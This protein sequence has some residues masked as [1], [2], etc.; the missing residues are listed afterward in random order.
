LWE[1]VEKTWTHLVEK[2]RK[3]SDLEN[4]NK[5]GIGDWK[6]RCDEM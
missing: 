6:K 1:L 5:S 2:G 3:K 4:W